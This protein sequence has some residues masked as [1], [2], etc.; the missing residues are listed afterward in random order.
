V[1]TVI[2]RVD[3]MILELLSEHGRMPFR[4]LAERVR[5]SA[6]ATADRVRR[7]ERQGVIR[8][9]R[10]DLDPQAMGRPLAALI[11]IRLSA[12]SFND[13]FEAAVL[14]HPAVVQALHLTGTFDYQVRVACRD[15]PELDE[16]LTAIKAIDGVAGT[17]T[18]LVL[19]ERVAPLTFDTR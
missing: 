2:D 17:E 12:G 15:V 18:R 14:A 1:T 9:Y 6:N 4:E 3:R 11:D 8:G 16:L 5:L 19:H 7:L 10:A 13:A